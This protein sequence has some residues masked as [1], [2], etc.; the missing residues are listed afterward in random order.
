MII[1]T[2]GI[3]RVTREMWGRIENRARDPSLL[4]S[5]PVM[6]EM[7]QKIHDPENAHLF[8]VEAALEAFKDVKL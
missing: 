4:R 6:E 3:P 5:F 8:T 2:K 7:P 1:S